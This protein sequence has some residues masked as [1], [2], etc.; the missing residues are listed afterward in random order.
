MIMDEEMEEPS[1]GDFFSLEI[2]LD[3]E[4][5]AVRYFDFSR[6]ES[7]A[8]A[9]EAQLWFETAGSYPPSPF[10]ARLNIGEEFLM[11]IN[12]LP[13][14]KDSESS[15][16]LHVQ[17]NTDNGAKFSEPDETTE[18][19]PREDKKFMKGTFSRGS[20]LMKPT[21]SHLAKQNHLREVKCYHL[22]HRFPKP[23]I[24]KR[25]VIIE[26]SS[27]IGGHSSKRQKLEGGHL[28]KVAHLKEPA[29]LLHKAP[30][31]KSVPIDFNPHN[32]RLRITIP[33][34][35]E[36]ETAQRA[37][38]QRVQRNDDVKQ[39]PEAKAT[40]I[41]IFRA[42][43]L[44]RKILEAPSQKK[45][46]RLPA[47][48]AGV[49]KKRSVEQKSEG[50]GSA[51]TKFKAQ[52][53]NKK[54][55]SSKG[56]VGIFRS[57]KRETTKPMEFSFSTSKRCH[58]DPPTELFNKLSLNTGMH[59]SSASYTMSLCN[60]HG[61]NKDLKENINSTIQQGHKDFKEN[62]NSTLLQGHK[63]VHVKEELTRHGIKD[64]V[65][66]ASTLP[67]NR[68]KLNKQRNYRESLGIR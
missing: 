16:Y 30:Q 22:V 52:P 53:L 36:L 64:I 21:A 62:I 19:V 47:F 46:P 37:Q 61:V 49:Q 48:Q 25:V 17:S 58:Q 29:D 33:R 39:P 44:N 28:R 24:Q 67:D 50:H 4:F 23:G 63:D 10:I 2:D 66:R 9:W 8:E 60:S 40:T 42:R 56:D 26:D 55:L 3:Y 12:T 51:Q 6:E 43:P 57:S 38:R 34:E 32:S 41:P 18:D 31:K 7:F 20:T 68:S 5:D 11:G 59:Q 27:E 1:R 15:D 54:I 13:N 45:T 14:F 35:P 65:S